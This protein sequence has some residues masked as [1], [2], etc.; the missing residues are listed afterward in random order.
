VDH[1]QRL[2]ALSIPTQVKGNVSAGGERF[3][4]GLRGEAGASLIGLD[5]ALFLFY[6]QLNSVPEL[7]LGLLDWK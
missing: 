4:L 1:G 6:C 5:G 2:G 7:F 3:R